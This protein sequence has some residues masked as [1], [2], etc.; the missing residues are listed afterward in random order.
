MNVELNGAKVLFEIPI[1]VPLL[2][3]IQITQ[4]VV[5]SWVIMGIISGLCIWLGKGLTVDNI[6]RKQAAAEVIVESLVKFV[7]GNMGGNFDYFIP[8][9]GA[10]FATSVVSNIIS[11]TG[12]WSPT[13]DLSTELAWAIVVF[14]L[15]TYYKLKSGG[16]GGYLKGF[17]EPIFLMAPLNVLSELSTPVS[18]AC[19]HFG[20]VLSGMVISTLLYASLASFSALIL[21]FIP[22]MVGEMLSAFPLFSIGI[23]AVLSLYFDWFSGCIQAFIFC[24]LTTIFIKQA[25]GDL[26]E[27]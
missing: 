12:I 21:G 15:I 2:G 23:P 9:I 26:A 18:M 14:I 3:Y 7:R 6:S 4:T 24:T 8:L 27:A 20:N 5:V 10:L 13:A 22:G 19:R 11:I 16:F 1:D 25:A 17:L